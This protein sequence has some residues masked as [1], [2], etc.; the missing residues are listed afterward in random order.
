MS[1]NTLKKPILNNKL[2]QSAASSNEKSLDSIHSI[3][4]SN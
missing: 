4:S 3:V 1:V 2:L